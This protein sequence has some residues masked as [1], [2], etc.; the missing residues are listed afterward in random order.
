MS[1]QPPEATN[2]GRGGEVMNIP[3]QHSSSYHN[4]PIAKG[5]LSSLI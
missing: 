4:N 1:G 5:S 2:D 3:L